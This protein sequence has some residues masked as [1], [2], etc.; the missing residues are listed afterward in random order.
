MCVVTE[1]H[2]ATR[3]VVLLSQTRLSL[4]VP[5]STLM[6]EPLDGTQTYCTLQ[7][8]SSVLWICWN[9]MVFLSYVCVRVC[10]CV[11][12]CVSWVWCRSASLCC[13]VHFGCP[14]LCSRVTPTLEDCTPGTFHCEW[15]LCVC[16]CVCVCVCV[17]ARACVCV[18]ARACLCCHEVLVQL[19]RLKYSLNVIEAYCYVVDKDILIL[20][21][22][23]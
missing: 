14:P 17:C 5:P 6:E 18:H 16:A 21:R 2:C 20:S 13:R 7:V 3:H 8:F 9:I 1:I 10:V 12:V 11:C 15:V 19:R 23:T 4:V 22:Y